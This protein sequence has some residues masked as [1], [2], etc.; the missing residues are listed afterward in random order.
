M[1]T[2]LANNQRLARLWENARIHPAKYGLIA[3]LLI[4]IVLIIILIVNYTPSPPLSS[5]AYQQ[6]DDK[7]NSK[8]YDANDLSYCISSIRNG[9]LSWLSDTNTALVIKSC[10][11][12][13]LIGND[14]SWCINSL[15]SSVR[16]AT[17]QRNIP[18]IVDGC[19][20]KSIRFTDISYCV[21]NAAD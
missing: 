13:T 9:D 15:S 19:V 17:D 11:R 6:V 5:L 14:F 2:R 7:C 21:A 18:Q 3:A 20:V 8:S 1:T 12:K 16:D 4:A 10:D